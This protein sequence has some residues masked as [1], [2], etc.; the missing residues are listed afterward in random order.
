MKGS[1]VLVI[2]AIALVAALALPTAHATSYGPLTVTVWTGANN[3]GVPFVASLPVP[4]IAPTFTF[5]YSG[6]LDFANN[7]PQGGSNTFGE[8][9]NAHASGITGLTAAA[10]TTLLNTQMSSIGETGDAI[11]T[12]MRFSGTY[13]GGG[14]ASISSDDGSSF[15]ANGSLIAA[16]SNPNPQAINTATGVI[17]NGTN[18][19]FDLVYVE[20]N[21]SPSDLIVSGMSPTPEPSSLFLFGTGLLGLAFVAYRHA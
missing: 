9:F 2:V 21:G 20:S 6:P 4:G 8:F 17:P 14:S 7:N 1:R 16:L 5:T 19:P 15:Y 10:L 3:T 12:Y 18:V 13:T 11:N